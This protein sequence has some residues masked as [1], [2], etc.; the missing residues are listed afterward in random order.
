MP[1]QAELAL[2]KLLKNKGIDRESQTI[3]KITPREHESAPMRPCAFSYGFVLR[4]QVGGGPLK[5]EA[6]DQPIE[7]R[8][9]TAKRF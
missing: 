9:P 6:A 2:S 5:T 1:A 8:P 3:H 7:R 4:D